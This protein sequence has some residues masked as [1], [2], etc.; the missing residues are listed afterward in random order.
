MADSYRVW[1]GPCGRPP[2]YDTALQHVDSYPTAAKA[3]N[4]LPPGYAP[5]KITREANGTAREVW[6]AFD[7]SLPGLW[8]DVRPST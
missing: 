2:D 6:P 4:S 7:N 8:R 3:M 1:C 5:I